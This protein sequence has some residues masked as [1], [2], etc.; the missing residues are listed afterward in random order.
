MTL[1]LDEDSRP[2]YLQAAE[3]LRDAILNGEYRSGERLLSTRVENAL[4]SLGSPDLESRVRAVDELAACSS[5][6]IERVVASFEAD[7]EARFLIFERLGRFGSLAVDP[8]VRLYREA[9]DESVRLMSASA[10][11]YMGCPEGVPSLMGALAAG[12][13]HLCMAA[14]SLSSAGVSEAAGPIENALL[15]CD[16]SD[17]KILECLTASLRRLKHPLSESARLLLSGIRP[18]WLRDSLLD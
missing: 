13:P 18:Q 12:N 9:G 1:P 7:E 3:A 4:K 6:I 17:V 14:T 16:I 11:I 15:E 5:A 8:M 10:L 2:P